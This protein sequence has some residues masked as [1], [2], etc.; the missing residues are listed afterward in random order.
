[1]EE[2]LNDLTDDLDAYLLE[3]EDRV[4]DL[5]DAVLQQVRGDD[6]TDADLNFWAIAVAIALESELRRLQ[7]FLD[8]RR[9]ILAQEFGEDRV[10]VS[11]RRQAANMAQANTALVAAGIHVKTQES[12][13]AGLRGTDLADSIRD[14]IQ[15]EI[16][17]FVKSMDTT[18]S[19]FDRLAIREV[20]ETQDGLWIYAGPADNRNRPFCADIVRRKVAFTNSGIDKLNTHPLLAAYVPPNVS[21][22]CG[23]Y[24][25][26]HVWWP[27]T[28]AEASAQNLTVES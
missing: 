5:T 7:T 9:Q 10:P 22:L 6:L 12:I 18:V 16:S 1:M 24:R 26:R 17:S 21:I 19:L 13:T 27:I 4:E 15:Q 3:A 23:G 14:V 20:G 28:R 11:I 8:Q 2:F 25:C